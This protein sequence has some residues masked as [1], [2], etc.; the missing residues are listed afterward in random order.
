MTANARWWW[1]RSST[2]DR[3][4]RFSGCSPAQTHQRWISQQWTYEDRSKVLTDPNNNA[5]QIIDY[6]S[7]LS[8]KVLPQASLPMLRQTLADASQL[9]LI[10]KRRWHNSSS[11]HS[12]QAQVLAN[13]KGRFIRIVE[14]LLD[15][16]IA[17]YPFL[18][19]IEAV[20]G[21]YSS[22]TSFV[23]SVICSIQMHSWNHSSKSLAFRTPTHSQSRY[24]TQSNT[25]P[26]EPQTP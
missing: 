19:A 23:I 21:P 7:H 3:W 24:A 16:Q 8:R 2:R 14:F 26:V 15:R 11:G 4:G 12:F 9:Q 18:K 5:L 22:T 10:T 25:T 13:P 1:P 20:D 17:T 6:R